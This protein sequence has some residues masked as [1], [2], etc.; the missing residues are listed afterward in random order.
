[1]LIL[2]GADPL[3]DFPDGDLAARG[4]AGAR[5]VIS[6][7]IFLDDSARQADVV[8]AAAG[9][10]ETAGT[11]TNIEGRISSVEQEITPPGTA[12][13]DW[14]LAEEL[15]LRL[16]ADLGLESVEDVWDEIER[17]APSHAGITR[18]LLA[19]SIGADGVVVPLPPGTLL[20]GTP[21]SIEG[22]TAAE[23][24][25]GS[26]D[27]VPAA[28]EEP[29]A[30]VSEPDGRPAL[31][32][33]AATDAP[34]PPPADSYSLRLVTTRKLYDQGTLVQ[35]APS[36][37]GLAPGTAL[38]LNPYDFDRLGISVG[39]RVKVTSSRASLTGEALPDEGVPRGAAALAL[40]QTGANP[41]ELIDARA[42]VTDVRVESL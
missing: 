11:T 34:V 37:A 14:M 26:E 38:R 27:E 17:V 2:L 40:N 39:G 3:R 33:F 21:V 28:A 9:Y 7:G 42:P 4:L 24:D 15:A 5:T 35:H 13:Q 32:T 22:A 29:A 20:D 41:T 30:A 25:A 12:R 31:V 6:V 23:T 18:S 8:L 1:V 19:S 36:L 16:G 10:A